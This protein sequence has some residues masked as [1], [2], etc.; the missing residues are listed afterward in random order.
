MYHD[1]A[2][3]NA[4]AE[5]ADFRKLARQAA[6]RAR[7]GPMIEDLGQIDAEEGNWASAAAQLQQARSIY[8]KRD[9]ILRTSLLEAN[10]WAKQGKPKRGLEVV[11]SVLRSCR[12]ADGGV[13]PEAGGGVGPSP[14][15]W[16]RRGAG[17]C[18]G[19][20]E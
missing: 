13:V 20:S 12:S 18:L 14:V 6:S 8:T 1:F 15:R 10:A 4:S 11:R 17:G 2:V 7:N 3:R 9:D 19:L 5:P 16:A